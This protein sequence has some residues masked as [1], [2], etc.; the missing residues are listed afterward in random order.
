MT[1]DRSYV[2]LDGK[3]AVVTGA[4]RGI[5]AATATALASF[6]ADLSLC[7]RDAEGLTRTAAEVTALGKKV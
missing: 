6:G 5:G 4:A 3:I 7:D 1:V 2:D